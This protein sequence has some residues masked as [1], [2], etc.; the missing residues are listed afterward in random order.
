MASDNLRGILLMLASMALFGMEDLFLKLAAADLPVGQVVFISGFFGFPVFALMAARQGQK[1]WT[2]AALHPAVIARNIGEMVGTLGYITALA[3]VPLATVSA[4]L[5]AMPLA[6]TL[7]AALFLKETVGWRRWTAIAAGFAG[8]L[9]VIRPG[10]EGFRPEAVWVLLSVAGLVL[11]DLSSRLIPG[12]SSTAQVSA[13]GLLAVILLGGLMMLQ[14][15]AAMPTAGQSGVLL[16]A[17]IFGTAGYWAVVAASR[18]GEVSVV[19][20][21]RYARLIFAILIGTLYFGEPLDALTLAGS[22]LIIASGLYAFARERALKR[23]ARA[24]P[25]PP[26]P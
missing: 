12:E 17:V 25:H 8:V 15:G 24:Q 10:M 20:P 5:Q 19:A 2:R 4:V 18:T 9:T 14:G 11:R 26:F 21:F 22:V 16:G 3:T 7:A 23:K 1:V 13:W 6:V